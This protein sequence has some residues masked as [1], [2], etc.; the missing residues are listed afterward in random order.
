M[1]CFLLLLSK[2]F[3]VTA[4]FCCH[5]CMKILKWLTVSAY[6]LEM[7]KI[8]ICTGLTTFFNGIARVQYHIA[9]VSCSFFIVTE[10]QTM[11]P[12]QTFPQIKLKLPVRRKL[13]DEKF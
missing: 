1:C 12:W 10:K 5:M 6:D 4:N 7:Q 8:L 3:V 9:S 2:C 13:A 11:P